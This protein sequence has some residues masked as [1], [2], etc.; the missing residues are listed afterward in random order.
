MCHSALPITASTPAQHPSFEQ[1][2]PSRQSHKNMKD[3]LSPKKRAEEKE[4]KS[5]PTNPI[6]F[7]FASQI[8][9]GLV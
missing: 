5:A 7:A 1:Q 6:P 4:E 8:S 2:P 9:E 3:T